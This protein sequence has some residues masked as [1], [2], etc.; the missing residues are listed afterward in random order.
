VQVPADDA[1]AAAAN[2]RLRFSDEKRKSSDVTHTSATEQAQPLET[3]SDVTRSPRGV[4]G[5]SMNEN[6]AALFG[7]PHPARLLPLGKCNLHGLSLQVSF[8]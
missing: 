4:G 8:D 7:P 3:S 1:R 6:L 2:Q 5:Q